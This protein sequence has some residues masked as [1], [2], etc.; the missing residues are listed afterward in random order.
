MKGPIVF[1]ASLVAAAT[2]GLLVVRPLYRPAPETPRSASLPADDP[3]LRAAEDLRLAPLPAIP[4]AGDP[5]SA[6][7][8]FE[9]PWDLLP[10]VLRALSGPRTPA[11]RLFRVQAT[12]DPTVCSV[13]VRW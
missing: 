8:R 3:L 13:E 4:A 2:I 11:P 1:L 10:G 5:P 9:I 7:R 12:T 6:V